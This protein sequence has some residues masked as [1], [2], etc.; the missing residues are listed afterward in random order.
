MRIII[1]VMP[2]CSGGTEVANVPACDKDMSFTISELW[3]GDDTNFLGC[4]CVEHCDGQ[5]QLKS[6]CIDVPN[7]TPSF[8]PPPSPWLQLSVLG[9]VGSHEVLVCKQWACACEQCG[10]CKGWA[11]V[12]WS[13]SS[14]MRVLMH[15]MFSQF[16]VPE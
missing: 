2:P 14:R 5:A 13:P 3:P 16:W 1:I 4:L 8:C 15:S 7:G 6:F 12:P 10:Q 11:I 9:P